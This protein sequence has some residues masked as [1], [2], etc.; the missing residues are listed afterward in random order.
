MTQA[1][2]TLLRDYLISQIM[3]DNANRAG[4]VAYMTVQEFQRARPQDD[5]HVVRVLKHKTVNTHGPA[6]IVLTNHLYNHLKIFVEKMR[7]QMPTAGPSEIDAKFFLSWG[8]ND[9]KSSQMS[10]ALQAIFQKAG[11][12]G[13]MSHTLYRKSAVSECHQNRKEISGN[14]ADLMAHRESTAEKYYRVL[15]KSRSSVKA[16]QVLHGIMRNEEKRNEKRLKEK[17]EEKSNSGSVE[18]M[19]NEKSNTG[20]VEEMTSEKRNSQSLEE[21]MDAIKKLFGPEIDAQS[22]SI[23]TVREKICL[24]PILCNE[25]AK[26]VYD[27]I[28]AQWRY[29]AQVDNKPSTA[30]LPSEKETVSDRV[31][32]MFKESNTHE[33]DEESFDSSDVVSPTETTGTSKPG[34]FSPTHVQTLL[35]LF[36]DMI[37]GSPISKPIITQKLQNDSE[38]KEMVTVFTVTQVVNRLKYERKQ[39]REK[40]RQKAKL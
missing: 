7:S 35:R 27:K 36:S 18:E 16:S 17:T 13:P 40:L 39:K 14:L 34:V 8:G 1:D 28:R 32:R 19:T 2:Y 4:V 20:S 31:E 23:A 25:D 3:I 12:E 22:I 11:I 29:K 33:D 38:G 21:K 15:D 26:K 30:S 37:N 24:N 5:R 9:M 6:Q 10:K